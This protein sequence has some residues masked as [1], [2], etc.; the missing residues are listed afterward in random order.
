MADVG[1]CNVEAILLWYGPSSSVG[2]ETG[3][4]LDGP[5]IETW[6]GRDRPWDP[7]SLQYIGY[8]VFPGGRKRPGRD[9]DPSPEV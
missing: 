9:A 3:Y 6:W 4:G 1:T 8:R 2:I 7:P 5:G